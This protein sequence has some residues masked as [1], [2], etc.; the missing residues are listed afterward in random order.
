MNFQ[1]SPSKILYPILLYCLDSEGPLH[2]YALTNLIEQKFNWKPSQTAIYNA[3][4]DL[5]SQDV[6]QSEEKIESGR[7]QKIYSITESGR[8]RFIL[9]KKEFKTKIMKDFQKIIAILGHFSELDKDEEVLSIFDNINIIS[10]IALKI[11]R[12]NTEEV[13]YILSQC[14]DALIKLVKKNEIPMDEILDESSIIYEMLIEKIKN[15]K[16]WKK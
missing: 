9:Q 8:N 16:T 13:S 1:I 2:G 10:V 3:L 15:D 4:R 14:S 7:V 6:L 11:M 12:Y 5:E